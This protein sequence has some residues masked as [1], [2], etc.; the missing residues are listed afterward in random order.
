MTFFHYFLCLLLMVTSCVGSTVDTSGDNVQAAHDHTVGHVGN[1]LTD[2][3]GLEVSDTDPVCPDPGAIFPCNCTMDY[4]FNMDLDCSYVES[5]D[6]LA[7][8]M[9]VSFPTPDFHRLTIYGNHNLKELRAGVLGE[10]ATFQEIWMIFGA[11][12]EV[13]EGALANSY[14]TATDIMFTSN[15]IDKFCWNDISSFSNLHKLSLPSNNLA[16]ITKMSSN[17]LHLLSLGKN[18]IRSLPLTAFRAM[19]NLQKIFLPNAGIEEIIPDT[20]S[21][22]HELSVVDLSHNQL[23][24]LPGG[25]LALTS[26]SHHEIYFDNNNIGKVAANAFSG[27][28]SGDNMSWNS[29]QLTVLESQVWRPLLDAGVKLDLQDN[30]LGCG[31]D[32]SWLVLNADYLSLIN[33]GTTCSDGE[34]FVDLDPNWFKENC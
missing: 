25:T 33:D 2:V 24:E 22:L 31:C 13:E 7:R 4:H 11:L 1:P 34:I 18:D 29:N 10:T 16:H 20:F 21:G 26:K 12:Q 6:Q 5:E 17:S 28:M 32:I 3:V 15:S 27:L 23:Q 30:P 14:S 8:I 19:P 9:N